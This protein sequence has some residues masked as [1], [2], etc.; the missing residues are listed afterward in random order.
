VTETAPPPPIRLVE[1]VKRF[2]PLEVLSGV[3]L[4]A[5]EGEVVSIL[6]G[7]G[8]GKSTLLRCI[9]MLE[10]PTSGEVIVDGETIETVARRDGGR[11]PRDRRQVERIRARIGMVFQSFELWSHMTLL[12]NVIEAPIRVQKRDRRE[13]IA[14]AEALLERVGIFDRRHHH[15]AHCSGGQQQRAAI[16]RA[17]AMRPRVMLFDEPTSALDPELVG[18]VLAVMRDLAAEGRTMLVVTHEMSFARD[19]SDRVVFLHR[20]RI[21]EEGPAQELFAAPRSDRFRRFLAAESRT[22]A[23]LSHPSSHRTI[24]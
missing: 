19:V 2:G 23:P 9:D 13:V 21:E 11:R 16:A 5:R 7:S 10:V 4:E 12:E 22:L 18:E 3:S 15:P 6:G 24:P 1:I 14:E 8:S 20:G 17:L